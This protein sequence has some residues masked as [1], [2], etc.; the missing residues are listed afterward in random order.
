MSGISGSGSGLS[1]DVDLPVATN[2]P[3]LLPPNKTKLERAL[4]GPT[5]RLDNAIPVPIDLLLQP[6]ACP[7]GYL[8]WLAWYLSLSL[9]DWRWNELKRRAVIAR[10]VELNRMKGTATAIR[11]YTEVMDSETVQIVVPPQEFYIGNPLTKAE[12]DTWIHK[13]PEVR[14]KLIQGVGVAALDSWFVQNSN[15]SAGVAENTTFGWIGQSFLQQDEGPV[16]YGRRVIVRQNGVD[17]PAQFVE[18][19]TILDGTTT[20]DVERFSTLGK[21]TQGWFVGVDFMGEQKFIGSNEIDPKLITLRL[22]GSYVH[23]NSVLGLSTVTPDL[24]PVSPRYERTSDIGD[25]G[26]YGFLDDMFIG[27][28]DQYE[29]ASGE[30]SV[31]YPLAIIQ[32][33]RA[34]D[35]LADR[36]FLIDPSVTVPIMQG[37]SFI[38]VSRLG[39]PAFTAEVMV[40]LHTKEPN[41]MLFVG[42]GFVGNSFVNE[43]DTYY[44]DRAMYAIRAS[45]A[46]RDKILVSFAPLRPLRPTDILTPDT[47]AGDWV[48]DR[49]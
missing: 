38:G 33:N 15:P 42:E 34:G 20:I 24:H 36:I 13:M 2:Y 8:P 18:R 35:L 30:T 4:A 27:A 16:L 12:W 7:T 6:W 41:D 49:L 45:K 17:V 1:G 29:M 23:D 10:A 44:M 11:E 31:E 47:K 9:W 28:F 39:M 21:S 40:D 37:M 26:P 25:A 14:I 5:G 32:K 19:T 46:V 48:P 3:D 43:L 22:D